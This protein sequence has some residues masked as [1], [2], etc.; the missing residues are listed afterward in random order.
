MTVKKRMA[1]RLLLWTAKP[2]WR[3]AGTAGRQCRGPTAPNQFAIRQA[4][5]HARHQQNP[6]RQN[7]RHCAPVPITRLPAISGRST[8][9][10]R[11]CAISASD[12]QRARIDDVGGSAF[13][14]VHDV[15]EGCAKVQLVA[16]LLHVADV[17]VQ[18]Q[19]SSRSSAW[20]WRIGSVSKTS[21]AASPGRPRFRALMS[22]SGCSSSA[23]DVLTN[24]EVGFMRR[25]RRV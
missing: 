19:L 18:M 21:T 9:G 6:R 24:K 20:P 8:A 12:L 22:T 13:D 11:V 4:Q 16:V 15:V 14:E 23:R 10:R 5:G 3:S 17:G 25:G 7:D 2:T 1:C